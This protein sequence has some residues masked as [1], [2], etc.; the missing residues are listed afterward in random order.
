[1]TFNPIP[2]TSGNHGGV[3]TPPVQRNEA[4][5]ATSD[6]LFFSSI[7]D[8]SLKVATVASIVFTSVATAGF[9]LTANP[10]LGIAAVVGG[11]TSLGLLFFYTLGHDL[12][13][14]SS[15]SRSQRNS[16]PSPFRPYDRPR[17]DLRRDPR[18]VPPYVPPE[19]QYNTGPIHLFGNQGTTSPQYPQDDRR[20]E[21][22]QVG[23]KSRPGVSHSAPS[24]IS[25][26]EERV[27]VGNHGT[28]PRQNE[29]VQVEDEYRPVGPI[30]SLPHMTPPRKDERVQVGNH[31]PN[32]LQ[33]PQVNHGNVR[34]QVGDKS[35]PG[36]TD[37]APSHILRGE[38]RVPVGNHGT[39]PLKNNPGNNG[40][41][42]VSVGKKK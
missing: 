11:A 8:I 40:E 7:L 15:A 2:E 27:Q 4:Q 22:V 41:E 21:R 38:E 42:R 17:G 1:M 19:D 6:N 36:A 16:P 28:T 9:L 24:H 33:N 14:S 3:S 37:S 20:E 13:E 5:D 25:R 29:G 26:G 31:R 34:V 32:P 30:S 10:V 12:G 23:D 35:R 18:Y 39:T